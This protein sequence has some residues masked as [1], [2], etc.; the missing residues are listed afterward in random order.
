LFFLPRNK[1][2]AGF[3]E[4]ELPQFCGTGAESRQNYALSRLPAAGRLLKI[5][6]I[7]Q[8]Y[9]DKHRDDCVRLND[10]RL[11]F[12]STQFSIHPRTSPPA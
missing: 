9:P 4:K 5:A 12:I 7:I 2:G 10:K 3:D 11:L 1:S 6:E 8:K